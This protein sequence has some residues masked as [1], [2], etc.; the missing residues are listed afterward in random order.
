MCTCSAQ[1]QPHDR[2]QNVCPPTIEE[3]EARILDG[4]E[5]PEEHPYADELTIG[6]EG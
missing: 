2:M 5:G 3:M 4:Q 6:G 1:L